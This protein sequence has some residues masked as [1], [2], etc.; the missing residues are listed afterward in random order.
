MLLAKTFTLTAWAKAKPKI[1][2]RMPPKAPRKSPSPKNSPTMLW[3]EA[4]RDFLR[5]ISCRLSATTA[6]MVVATQTMVK[7]KTTSVTM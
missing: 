7:I 2:P 5:P 6:I 3:F 4:P 1:T